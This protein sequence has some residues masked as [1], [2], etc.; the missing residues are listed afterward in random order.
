M[1]ICRR[2]FTAGLPG[3]LAACVA[4]EAP[5]PAPSV[6]VAPPPAEPAPPPPPEPAPVADLPYRTIYAANDRERFWIPAVNLRRIDPRFL[7]REVAYSR[8]E[9]PGAIVVDTGARFAYLVMAGGRAMR[10]GIAVGREEAFNLTGDTYIGRK[11]EWPNWRP[12]PE[13]VARDPRRYAALRQGLPGGGRNPLGA[14]ALYLYRDG[15]DTYYRLHGTVEPWTI[16]TMA[17]AGC[18]RLINQDI[19]DLY[20]RV[21]IGARVVILPPDLS[22]A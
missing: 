10:Y 15:D 2:T 13:M 5:R 3:L 11:A 9:E 18:V 14:R 8:D 12:T 7:R 21:E 4:P 19:I 22:V 20:R 17:S 1:S 16:G 6:E